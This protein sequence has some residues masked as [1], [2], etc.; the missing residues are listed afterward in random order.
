SRLNILP[1]A[2]RRLLLLEGRRKVDPHGSE[3]RCINEL[4]QDQVAK[5]S[6]AIA[7]IFDGLNITYAELNRRAD[8]LAERLCMMGV[9]P[10]SL[11]AV[12]LERSPNVIVAITG[13]LKA[14]AAYVP[15]DPAYP[16]QRLR[17]MIEDS[18]AEVA[19]TEEGLAGVLAFAE[20]RV[21]RIDT[22]GVESIA[23]TARFSRRPPE[24]ENPAY[25][26]YTSGSTGQP[27]GVVVTHKNVV[28]LFYAT[29]DQFDFTHKDVWTLFHSYAFDFSVW[30]IWGALLFGGVIVIVPYA[31]SRDTESFYQLVIN[32]GVTVL[33]QTP[34]AFR[35]F[36][37][38]DQLAN[39]RAVRSL[40]YVI[41]GGEK[42]ETPCLAPWM[43]RHGAGP[44]L[45]NMYGIT[46]TTVHVT[47]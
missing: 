36:I 21:L 41:F 8:R 44:A 7:V 38:H 2:E 1:D 23:D 42:L 13:I 11:V 22:D 34:S 9:G 20:V 32:E 46:E 5:A 27:K 35:Q 16:R 29:N 19:V 26:I 15:L 3:H 47:R 10:E 4:F 40:R 33:N 45:I 18:G 25:V 14:G 31:V 37:N 12:Y 17:F 24:P 43:E 6:D 28:R 30:E 39:D